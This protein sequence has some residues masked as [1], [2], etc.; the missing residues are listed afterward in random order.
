ME[1]EEGLISV[2]IPVYNVEEYL[3][4][5]ICSVVEQSYSNIEI[6]LIDDGS[7]DM[8]GMICDAWANKD[9]R[10][11]VIHKVNGGLSDSRNVG[12][13]QSSGDFISFVDSDDYIEKNMLK[14]LHLALIETESDL[15]ICDFNFVDEHYKTIHS[16]PKTLKNEILSTQEA[17][18]KLTLENNFYYVTAVNRLYKKELFASLKFPVGKIHEDEFTVHHLFFKCK[19]VVTIDDKL[20]NYF[21]RSNSIMHSSF[22]IK[23]LDGIYAMLDRYYFLKNNGFKKE[24]YFS[25][26]QA[27]YLLIVAI[28][29]LPVM[30][31]KK[32]V[33]RA[34]IAVIRELKCNPRSVKILLEYMIKM[35]KQIVSIGIFMWCSGLSLYFYKSKP[36]I[37]MMATPTHGNLGDQAIVY[38]EYKFLKQY[39]KEYKIIEICNDDY[40]RYGNLIGKLVNKQDIIVIDGGGN[41]GTL[42]PEEDDK[43]GDI[44]SRFTSHNI[45]IFPQTCYYDLDAKG[46]K[47]LQKNT[48]IY[49]R[50]TGLHIMLRDLKSYQLVKKYFPTIKKYFVPDIVLKIDDLNVKNER[51]GALLCFR[52]DHEKMIT[53]DEISNL[54]EYLKMK[55]IGFSHTTTVIDKR[56]G[57][58]NRVK[59]LNRKW[60]EFGQSK[61]VIT[62]RLHGMIFA[63]ITSTPCIAI[64]NRSK[65]VSGVYQWINNLNFIKCVDSFESVHKEIGL[66][67]KTEGQKYTLH[68]E[69]VFEDVVTNIRKQSKI[70]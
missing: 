12:I 31:Y 52:H 29:N 27:Y 38:A 22:S 47:R 16:F 56:V 20:Y 23:K 66:L 32:E 30:E 33:Y 3:D 15:A 10:I 4:K 18:K 1:K 50:C 11:K 57:K 25:L 59:E 60:R 39:F 42:W 24:S 55:D 35:L 45:I 19:R 8:S 70:D 2:I 14:K 67:Y 17:L 46:K 41:L 62:D 26:L 37:I 13:S 65:K 64:D 61:L 53:D 48:D 54:E 36:K 63:A 34:V 28:R 44:I 43:L 5:C 40:L 7:T 6:L 51:N 68:K 58:H 49:S 21:Q 69:K 9:N